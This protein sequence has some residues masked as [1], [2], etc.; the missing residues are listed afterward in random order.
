LGQVKS[1][2]AKSEFL[3]K[4]FLVRQVHRFVAHL[5]KVEV[6]ASLAQWKG[7]DAALP[8][9]KRMFDDFMHGVPNRLPPGPF[10]SGHHMSFS[11]LEK[12]ESG[13]GSNGL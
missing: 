1:D 7:H 3:E 8:Q 2:T 6:L 5:R 4:F 12:H 10:S 13:S 11:L 9:A